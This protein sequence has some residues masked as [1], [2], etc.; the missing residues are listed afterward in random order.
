MLSKVVSVGDKLELQK[1][2]RETADG[3]SIA[4]KTYQSRVYDILSE[5]RLEITMPIEKTKLILLSIDEEYDLTF[6]CEKGLFQCYARVVDRYKTNNIYI[7]AM[8]LTSNLRKFQ[9]REFYR[10]SCALGML[11]RQLTD[12][13]VARVK[14]RRNYFEPEELPMEKSVIV[15]ISGGGLRFVTEHRYEKDMLLYC[16]CYLTQNGKEK[17]HKLIVQ[18]L[19]V[20]ESDKKP[21]IYEHRV[22][23]VNI[24]MENR[25]EIIRYIF[26][27]E[28]KHRNRECGMKI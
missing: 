17:L 1:V 13:E 10:F 8:E 9:R 27:E 11:S 23:Y 2:G 16:Q 14:E 12:G 18:V 6:F 7:L 4:K 19:S 22:Q 25:E 21:G 5:D 28:R 24:D 26:E 20:K 15:D 3:D